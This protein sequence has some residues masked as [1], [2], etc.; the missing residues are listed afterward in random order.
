MYSRLRKVIIISTLF[1]VPTIVH[2]AEF[3][4]VVS[5]GVWLSDKNVLAGDKVKLYTVISNNDFAS[6]TTQVQ[7]FNSGKKIGVVQ[8]NNLVREEARQIALEYTL[9]SGVYTISV[10]LANAVGTLA[11]GETRSLSDAE[12]K[13]SQTSASLNVDLDTDK[14]RLGNLV[15]TDDDNDGVLDA[16][17]TQQG[18]DPLKSDTD[19]D[20]LS[21]GEEGVLGSNPLK[22]DTDGDGLSD[23]DE[24]AL[25]TSS[26][27]ADTDGDGLSD[28][29]EKKRGTNPLLKDT[30]KDGVDDKLDAFPLD[31]KET[32]D[33]DGDGRGDNVDTD[34]DND[35]QT[36]A[37]EKIQGT[38]PRIANAPPIIVNSETTS[39]TIVQNGTSSVSKN[40]VLLNYSDKTKSTKS[41]FSVPLVA[42]IAAVFSLVCSI[43][44]WWQ[45]W[46]RSTG[47]P[48][49]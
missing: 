28:L 42:G 44:F 14:D 29:E 18:T 23:K 11:N 24:K 22:V 2:A 47:S 9:P 8:V 15:D 41:W 36:D 26:T 6:L 16:K 17:E 12:L 30:D 43:V 38:N 34:D 19:G 48:R 49:D 3:D 4:F 10:A 35:A 33:T 27:K 25:G 31:P 40:S 21:D 5:R 7:F 1:L 13:A 45:A 37:V 39:V 46:R 32:I 20:G